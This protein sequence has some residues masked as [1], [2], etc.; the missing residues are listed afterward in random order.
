M[1]ILVN[2]LSARKGGIVTYTKN[3]LAALEERGFDATVAVPPEFEA[4]GSDS[5]QRVDVGDYSPLRRFMWE[6]TSWRRIVKHHNPD[7]L[8]SSANFGLLSSPV[9]QVLLL[10]EGGLFDPF[11]LANMAAEQG[12]SPSINRVFR[13][14]LMLLS[15]QGANQIITPTVAMRDMLANWM[16]GIV[17][18]CNVN[19]YGT[20]NEAFTPGDNP[21]PWRDGGVLRLLYVSVYY[22]H[23]LPGLICRAVDLLNRQGIPTEATITMSLDEI[24]KTL[25]GTYDQIVVRD[26][27]ERGIVTLGNRPYSSLPEL[28]RSHDVFVFPSVSET[29]GHPMA[30]AMSSG[31]PVVA[32]STPVNREICGDSAFYFEPFIASDLV[33]K[34]IALDADPDLRARLAVTGRTRTLERYGWEDHVDRLIAV[35]ERMVAGRS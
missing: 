11:Y 34:I 4:P 18:K 30:E 5:T 6:Q 14:R 32:S 33:D 26:A 19:P 1:K 15:A 29:F 16:P 7:V 23:K 25:G 2:A 35:F 28:Y 22:P 13:R 27:A 10:R 3:L 9:Q 31:L 24:D 12:V 8:F 21:R 20:L 17:E